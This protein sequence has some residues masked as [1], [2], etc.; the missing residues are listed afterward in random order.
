MAEYGLT[1]RASGEPELLAG[2]V[3]C[4]VIGAGDLVLKQAL[5]KLAVQ[6]EWF[7]PVQRI[8]DEAQA[9]R[10][11]EAVIPGRAPR[12][13]HFDPERQIVVIERAP[14]DWED[15]ST[16]FLSGD[17]APG[18]GEELGRLL[19]DWHSGT[20]RSDYLAA[21]GDRSRFRALRVEPF[22]VTAAE[23]AP[24][25]ADRIGQLIVEME[26][27][28][29]S[30]VHGD[31]SPKNVLAGNL[32]GLW[33]IDFETTHAGDPA[34]D[35]AFLLNHVILKS[36]HLPEHSGSLDEVARSFLLTYVQ[37]VEPR[38]RPNPLH[39]MAHVSAQMLA[40]VIGKSPAPYLDQ[41]ER[42]RIQELAE[43]LLLADTETLDQIL[44]A[45]DR[46]TA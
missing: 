36:I 20:M 21:F 25:V 35:V 44:D 28:Q 5:G 41:G 43:E 7:A 2:G 46:V 13:L 39:L 40:R 31:F 29:V 37:A 16:R 27:M 24:E 12:V 1:D 33:A 14:R 6:D 42:D 4:T 30:L 11:A 15:L 17:I 34:F 32:S 22:Y 10:I 3:S 19:A 9:L 18:I 23:R 8:A 26:A 38:I 45:R